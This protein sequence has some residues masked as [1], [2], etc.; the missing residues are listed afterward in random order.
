MKAPT[1]QQRKQANCVNFWP[2]SRSRPPCFTRACLTPTLLLLRMAP[3]SDN[4]CRK[5]SPNGLHHPLYDTNQDSGV[6]LPH[7]NKTTSPTGPHCSWKD[8]LTW[9]PKPLLR[10]FRC[11]E[12]LQTF[13]TFWPLP[14]HTRDPSD[15]PTVTR[16]T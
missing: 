15:A 12:F 14:N 16:T 6:P 13:L 11:E 8:F 7:H 1:H 3:H 2:N 9:I 10:T 4:P 5:P